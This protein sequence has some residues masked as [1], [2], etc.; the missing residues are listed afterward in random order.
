[1]SE[2]ILS[3]I[4]QDE[5]NNK[6]REKGENKKKKTSVGIL[7]LTDKQWRGCNY[8][9]KP[10]LDVNNK[11]FRR[12]PNPIDFH[13]QCHD[14]AGNL[15]WRHFY[16]MEGS[17]HY[18][19]ITDSERKLYDEALGLVY[20]IKDKNAGPWIKSTKSKTLF[21][22]Y[23]MAILATEDNRSVNKLE[24]PTLSLVYHNSL[25]FLKEFHKSKNM[26]TEIRGSESWILDYYSLDRPDCVFACKTIKGDIGFDVSF[27]FVDGRKTD[28][29]ADQLK[30]VKETV[31]D[32][33]TA[34]YSARFDPN[35]FE[36]LKK[37]CLNWFAEKANEHTDA[38]IKSDLDNVATEVEQGTEI[39]SSSVP[40]LGSNNGD[41]PLPDASLQM[42]G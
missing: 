9:Y 32:L 6:P 21:Y 23:S 37:V 42:K 24:A 14:D 18:Q 36:E 34:L 35:Y 39:N 17:Q 12:I 20:Q 3:F 30:Q 31:G 19:G 13:I 27:E 29:T 33:D 2:D 16:F 38:P 1:M 41:I 15:K 7:G 26:K 5:E 10:I 28:V 8:I 25:N 11:P 22:G 4:H 40:P